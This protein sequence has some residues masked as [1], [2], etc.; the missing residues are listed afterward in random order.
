ML[1]RDSIHDLIKAAVIQVSYDSILSEPVG[2][3]VIRD[4]PLKLIVVSLLTGEI[5]RWIQ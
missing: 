2:E 3:L 4:L 5:V 1:V